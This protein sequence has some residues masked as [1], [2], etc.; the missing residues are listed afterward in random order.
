MSTQDAI[1]PVVTKAKRAPKALFTV[2]GEEITVHDNANETGE[3]R[4]LMMA[5]S[6]KFGSWAIT[7]EWP[8][9]TF[10]QLIGVKGELGKGGKLGKALLDLAEGIER[11]RLDTLTD[12]LE[13]GVI[14]FRDM[15]AY[16]MG[17]DVVYT[18]HGERVS[19]TVKS[20]TL[21]RSMWATYYKVEMEVLHCLR[22][23]PTISAH[24]TQV[25]PWQG[26]RPVGE[27]VVQVLS[28]EERERLSERGK[29]LRNLFGGGAQY[30]NYRGQ[31]VVPGWWEDK[32]YRADGRVM[33]DV[34]TMMSQQK[35]VYD[36]VMR[37][38]SLANKDD[39]DEGGGDDVGGGVVAEE[40]DM[41]RVFPFACGFSFKVKQWGRLGLTGISQ[42][43]WREDAFDLLVLPEDEKE[44]VRSVV[45][46]SQTGQF[47]DI[48]EDKGGGFIFLLH[49]PPGQG[50]TLTAETVAEAL[51]RP[52]YSVTVGELGVSPD[53]LEE[54]LRRILDIATT[55]NAVLLLDE[56]DIFLEARDEHDVLRNAMVGVFLRLLEY[57][58]GVLFLTTN[59]VANIDRAFY[60]RI[61]V[62]LKFGESG[63]Q[64]RAQIWTNLLNAAGL[65]GL[66]I[67]RLAGHDI[68]GRQI[69]NTIRLA[70]TLAKSRG[71]EVTE[72]L[73]GEVIKLT[74]GFKP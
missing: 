62:P 57:H 70:Q 51:K 18:L 19:G 1:E 36:K 23:A 6:R 34:A 8:S 69:K 11:D 5:L 9:L 28:P 14:E 47:T 43:K 55:W 2:M 27:L 7:S 32:N 48:V 73:M 4:Y 72:T 42:V 16:L 46:G 50:K 67:E 30:M 20:V 40:K 53:H 3:M 59:R 41:W 61:S 44:L 15:P 71:T 45:D 52:L 74:T 56:A 12:K 26:L 68:N 22:G 33:I 13:R 66:D 39:D 49:G 37:S 17:K 21:H 60:S 25:W 65:K 58:Q 31:L 54:R 35:D 29:G 64:K 24:S 10:D 63:T 38:L